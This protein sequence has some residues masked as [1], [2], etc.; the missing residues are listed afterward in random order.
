MLTI[1]SMCFTTL[2]APPSPFKNLVVQIDDM[3]RLA[4]FESEHLIE[5]IQILNSQS[6]ADASLSVIAKAQKNTSNSNYTS[7][8][9]RILEQWD[10]SGKFFWR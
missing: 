8:F 7:V 10:F 3:I 5:M 2:Q 4:L 6:K 9:F 1:R